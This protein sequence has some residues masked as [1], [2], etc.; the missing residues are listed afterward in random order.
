VR[1]DD[2]LGRRAVRTTADI[3]A[4]PTQA[5]VERALALFAA[6]V[7]EAYGARLVGLHLFGSRAR[8]DHEPFSDADVAVVLEG[9]VERLPELRR[10]AR[11]T[12]DVLMETG[13]D[14]QPWPVALDA[15]REPAGQANAALIAS[16][17]RDAL[18]IA[19]P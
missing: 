16:M 10:L 18:R 1:A 5:D 11:L 4:P 15:W 17:R 8:G 14:V 3:L 13:V 7:R 6:A 19:I 9:A 12:H 2:D